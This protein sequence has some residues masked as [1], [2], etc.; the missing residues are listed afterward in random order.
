M[1]MLDQDGYLYVVDRKKEMIISGGENVYS[2]EVEA[3]LYQHP[4]ILEAAL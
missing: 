3:V 4:A 1:G 2:T